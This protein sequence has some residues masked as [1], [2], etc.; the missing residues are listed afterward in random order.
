MNDVK[1]HKP[2]DLKKLVDDE[3]Q[4]I[5]SKDLFNKPQ[6]YKLR[7]KWCAAAF[8]IGYEKYVK[9]CS[10]GINDTSQSVEADFFLR[11]EDI[12][13]PF[14][15]TE[16]LE[17]GRKRGDEY[18]KYK[19]GEI[20]PCNWEK[21]KERISSIKEVIERKVK[22]Y[23]SGASKLNLLIYVNIFSSDLEYEDI[24]ESVILMKDRFYSI[25]L[26]SNSRICS[27]FSKPDVGQIIGWREIGI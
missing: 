9:P 10:V 7:E 1:F 19:S 6:Y 16:V 11:T 20:I 25:W 5:P 2:H 17:K 3:I 18:K 24:L 26:I 4:F 13:Y 12:T 8:G 23:Y 27:L 14:Q 21:P 15:I 22:K